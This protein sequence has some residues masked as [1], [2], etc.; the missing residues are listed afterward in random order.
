MRRVLGIPAVFSA[1]YGNVGSSIYYALGIVALVAMGATPVALGIA[2]VLF[3]FTA[4]T[5]AE[6]TAALP[7]AGGSASFARHGFND[8]AGFIAG[9]ALMLSYI[10]TI[11]ISAFTIPPYLGFF[12]E[13]FKDSAI[14]GTLASVAIVFFLMTLNVIGI[15]ETSFVNISAAVLDLAT[16]ISLVVIGFIL[17]FNPTVIIRRIVDNWPAPENLIIGIALAAIA[18]TGI[19]TMSQMAEET[20]QPQKRVPRALVMMIVAVLVIFAGISLVSLSAM[21][22]QEL[23]SDWSRDPVAGIAANLPLVLLQD[24]LKPLIAILAGTILLIATNA[25]LIGIS[26]LA[27]SLGNHRLVPPALSRIHP[28]FKTPYISIILFSVIAILILLPGFFEADVFKNMG[29]LYAVGSLLAF[30]F[31]HASIIS[32]RIRRP[33]L[34]RPFK[35]GGNIKIK[36]RELPISALLGICALALIWIIIL[37][38][39]PYSRWV[40][41]GWMVLGIIIYYIYRKR[42]NLPLTHTP[43][44]QEKNKKSDTPL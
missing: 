41:L 36:G 40:G 20:K 44:D 31:A 3:I 11:S 1:G 9:W 6:G 14:I 17:L 38:T 2:G 24:V 8:L 33:E 42:E 16:Q 39:Q 26:R 23:A 32:L 7:E 37:I 30:M 13:P 22:P 25:G 34:P 12:W 35:L 5:Y 29:A 43:K 19:E 18:Y 21:T 15:K 27:F 10:V 4:L 28:R